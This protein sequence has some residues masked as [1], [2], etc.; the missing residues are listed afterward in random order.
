MQD[1]CPQ[2][3]NTH[4]S[5]DEYADVVKRIAEYPFKKTTVLEDAELLD[6]DYKNARIKIIT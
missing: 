1:G 4:M 5:M 3:N 2:F 6:V